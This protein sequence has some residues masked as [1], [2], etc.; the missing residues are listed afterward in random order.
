MQVDM[1]KFTPPHHTTTRARHPRGAVTKNMMFRTFLGDP[2]C[3]VQTGGSSGTKFGWV[4]SGKITELCH[5]NIPTLDIWDLLTH[6]LEICATRNR[7]H[8]GPFAHLHPHFWW[9]SSQGFFR[10]ITIF[11]TAPVDAQ[12]RR[13]GEEVGIFEPGFHL[14]DLPIYHL[15]K[16]Q[17]DIVCYSKWR[18]FR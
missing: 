1:N 2:K 5:A 6:D 9:I 7:Q 14:R 18:I 16:W 10:K 15:V 13:A 4:P 11:G 3:G 8:C 12:Q 17:F